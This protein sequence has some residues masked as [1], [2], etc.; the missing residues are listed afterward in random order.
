MEKQSSLENGGRFQ[1]AVW[2][3][4]MALI[5]TLLPG[6]LLGLAGPSGADELPHQP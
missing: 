5:V 4:L 2:S 3:G 1:T 6:L